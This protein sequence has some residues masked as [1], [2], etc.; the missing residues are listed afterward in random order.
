MDDLS[1]LIGTSWTAAQVI[2]FGSARLPRSM[3]NYKKASIHAVMQTLPYD[4]VG[5]FLV[6]AH[7]TQIVQLSWWWCN[8]AV[9][10]EIDANG[11]IRRVLAI[12]NLSF[13][14]IKMN[15]W[16]WLKNG[17]TMSSLL[18][19]WWSDIINLYLNC[20]CRY[21]TDDYKVTVMGNHKFRFMKY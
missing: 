21:E 10:S 3:R 2:E 5:F 12:V 15:W 17:L 6:S 19:K 7:K 8:L 18:H 13:T 9:Y 1:C 14:L 20:H 4:L 16:R 11:Y